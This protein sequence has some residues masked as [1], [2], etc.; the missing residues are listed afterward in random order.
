MISQIM[1]EFDSTI[2]NKEKDKIHYLKELSNIIKRNKKEIIKYGNTNS[3]ISK[4]LERYE[5]LLSIVS[6]SWVQS[7][8]ILWLKSNIP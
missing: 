5:L 7:S 4:T 1:Y 6:K 3:L 8:K 2:K